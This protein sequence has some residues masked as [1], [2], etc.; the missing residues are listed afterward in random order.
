MCA[1]SLAASYILDA[2]Q[3]VTK[4]CHIVVVICSH[5]ATA[6]GCERAQAI[7]VCTKDSRLRP[8]CD[9]N[10]LILMGH[11]RGAKL[12]CFIAEQVFQPC[13]GKHCGI[14]TVGYHQLGVVA[15]GRGMQRACDKGIV[16]SCC[17]AW[18]EVCGS[19]GPG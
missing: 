14:V 11:S 1:A 8:F 10:K 7:E 17:D 6:A 9:T 2:A 15:S 18:A 3:Y 5:A 4:C 19:A 16:V 13:C 12:S